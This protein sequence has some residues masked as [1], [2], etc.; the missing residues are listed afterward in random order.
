MKLKTG[1]VI[2]CVE[3][4][5]EY[6]EGPRVS[7]D[8][9]VA[10]FEATYDCE[11]F[12]VKFEDDRNGN[13]RYRIGCRVRSDTF[14]AVDSRNW[15]HSAYWYPAD[16]DEVKEARIIQAELARRKESK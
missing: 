9:V 4:A 7:P 8:L 5:P 14:E 13:Y 6:Y 3:H 11:Y 15:S 16:A 12:Y 1:D 2:V 10:G